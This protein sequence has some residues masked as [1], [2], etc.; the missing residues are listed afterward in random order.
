MTIFVIDQMSMETKA[1]VKR[2]RIKLCGYPYRVKPLW[3]T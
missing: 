2:N 1:N 3:I